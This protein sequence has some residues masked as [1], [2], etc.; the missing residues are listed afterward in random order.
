MIEQ[1]G[2]D[3]GVEFPEKRTRSSNRIAR[4][5]GWTTRSNIPGPGGSE[6]P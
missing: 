1:R 5:G 2:G 6:D 3:T 4:T